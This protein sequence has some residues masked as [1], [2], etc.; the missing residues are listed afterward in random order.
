M[1]GYQPS[2]TILFMGLVEKNRNVTS[3]TLTFGSPAPR[4]TDVIITVDS[5][6]Q[7]TLACSPSR[8]WST[9][10]VVMYIGDREIHNGN[11]VLK[12][13]FKY[14]DNE[15]QLYCEAYSIPSNDISSTRH[16]LYIQGMLHVNKCFNFNSIGTRIWKR[17]HDQPWLKSKIY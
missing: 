3:I 15:N 7:P 12:Y 13:T 6:V 5:G 2:R 1:H 4:D 9:A 10:T 16:T 14:E 11:E 17:C 8:S